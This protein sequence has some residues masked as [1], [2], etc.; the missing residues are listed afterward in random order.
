MEEQQKQSKVMIYRWVHQLKTPLSV[1]R[2]ISES[3]K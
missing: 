1:I 3:K 2:L